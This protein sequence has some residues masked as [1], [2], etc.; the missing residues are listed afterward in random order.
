MRMPVGEKAKGG[1]IGRGVVNGVEGK[2]V[3][4]NT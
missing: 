1:E 3:E 2:T 4:R